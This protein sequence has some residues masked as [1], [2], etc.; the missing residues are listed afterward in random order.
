MTTQNKLEGTI[1]KVAQ[2]F[3]LSPEE[4]EMLLKKYRSLHGCRCSSN[5]CGPNHR[6]CHN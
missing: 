6:V 5:T 4:A 2:S 3:N 1:N